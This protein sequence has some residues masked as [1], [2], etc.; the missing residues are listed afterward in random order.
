MF[1][2]AHSE[3]DLCSVLISAASNLIAFEV[4]PSTG[5]KTLLTAEALEL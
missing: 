2:A 1:T 4:G 3:V 5:G